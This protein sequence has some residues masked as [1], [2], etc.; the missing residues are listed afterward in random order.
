MLALWKTSKK[1]Q[2]KVTMSRPY[3]ANHLTALPYLHKCCC[4]APTLSLYLKSGAFKCFWNVIPICTAKKTGRNPNTQL[5]PYNITYLLY[6]FIFRFTT[7][8]DNRAARKQQIHHSISQVPSPSDFSQALSNHWL[9]GPWLLGA[10]A[11]VGKRVPMNP[12][13]QLLS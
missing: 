3:C 13:I 4:Y 1:Q 9:H 8:Y 12:I 7:Y 6:R 10:T 11:S 5:L 2:H